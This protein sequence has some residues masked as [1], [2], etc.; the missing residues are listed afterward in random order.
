MHFVQD[1]KES[2]TTSQA[3]TSASEGEQDTEMLSSR[4]APEASYAALLACRNK[5]NTSPSRAASPG[6][7]THGKQTCPLWI[8][9]NTSMHTPIPAEPKQHL[10]MSLHLLS[11]LWCIFHA[12]LSAQRAMCVVVLCM[13]IMRPT[14][15]EATVQ[16]AQ[17]LHQVALAASK[18]CLSVC[19]ANPKAAQ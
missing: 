6:A 12:P 17:H 7:S 18:C 3:S 15:A 2:Q 10:Q 11:N 1:G 13:C 4:S 19:I 14:H 5:Q 9:N 16:H 8:S